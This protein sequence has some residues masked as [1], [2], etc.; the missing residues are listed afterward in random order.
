M[1]TTPSW[2][3]WVK[4]YNED[5]TPAAVAGAPATTGGLAQADL[6]NVAT[7]FDPNFGRSETMTQGAENAAAGGWGGGGF[8]GGQ[9]LKLLDSEK[10][11]NWELGHK[12]LEPYLQRESDA[13]LQAESE[14][15]RLNEIAA[16]GAQ[17]LQQLQLSEAGTTARLNSSQQ[18][19]LQRLAIQGQQAMDQLRLK[20]TGDTARQ[21][22]A[23][24]GNLATTLLSA[25]VGR[26]GAG[27]GGGAGASRTPGP[28]G[29]TWER[30]IPQ[31]G[32]TPAS[33][34]A[35]TP[36][37]AYNPNARGVTTPENILGGNSIDAIL[38]KYGLLALMLCAFFV[39]GCSST[40][41]SK[42]AS[43][44]SKD[45]ATVF[46]SVGSVYGTLKVVRA[47]PNTNQ[48]C[49][50]SPDGTVTIGANK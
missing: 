49:T 34:T 27:G 9:G 10:K 6:G 7:I 18:A 20:E 5:N 46:V 11:S 26:G 42:L 32:G 12:M 28:L 13:K 44:L 39:S 8:S 43:E 31:Y 40:N 48:S 41:I 24:G 30:G 38:R 1:A 29:V 37:A 35:P 45:N 4:K 47:N 23:I 36:G 21:Q 17:A 50:I 15:A 33:V 19:E 25:A 14:K 3:E 2:E 16:Q 22:A